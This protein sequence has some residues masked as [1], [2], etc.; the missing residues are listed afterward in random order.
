M[1]EQA[2]E[3]RVP[4]RNLSCHRQGYARQRIFHEDE[5]D[6]QRLVDGLAL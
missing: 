3:S 4:W 2:V 6:H 5:A 1:S